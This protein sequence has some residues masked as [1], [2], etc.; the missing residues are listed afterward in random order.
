MLPNYAQSALALLGFTT[1]PQS[2]FVLTV[3]QFLITCHCSD[4]ESM[5][6]TIK[7]VLSDNALIE[8]LSMNVFCHN[9]GVL[10]ETNATF[11]TNCGTRV[12]SDIAESS[13]REVATSPSPS[14]RVP[15]DVSVVQ[16]PIFQSAFDSTEPHSPRKSMVVPI[17]AVV[18]LVAGAI[19][20]LGTRQLG[21]LDAVLGETISQSEAADLGEKKYLAG[22]SVGRQAGFNEGER[23]GYVRGVED[24]KNSGGTEGY[25]QGLIAGD[26]EGFTR[27]EQAGYE[28][29]LAAGQKDGY[30]TGF[31]DGCENVFDLAGYA[32]A[33]I[34]YSPSTRTI[35][36]S[37]VERYDVC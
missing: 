19:F 15:D 22:E 37:W 25:N 23:A 32:G 14:L 34:A 24:G 5:S 36:R 13:Q 12:Q 21:L 33:V 1:A 35:G 17:V 26:A 4:S 18:S 31:T 20:S 6:V 16:S 28:K 3:A 7:A 11:C 27:G 8:E 9:C 10:N 30:N 29:G 2:E